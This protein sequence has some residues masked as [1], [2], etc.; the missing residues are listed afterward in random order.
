MYNALLNN[1]RH[2][3]HGASLKAWRMHGAG[4][5]RQRV[6][7]F[8]RTSPTTF[9]HH[10]TIRQTILRRKID[11]CNYATMVTYVLCWH[12]ANITPARH[13]KVASNAGPL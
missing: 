10:F 3:K 7:R 11:T 1:A 4:Q 2:N 6:E 9:N 5:Q 13:V 8:C 12:A